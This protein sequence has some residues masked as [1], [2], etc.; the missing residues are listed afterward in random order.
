MP[1]IRVEVDG[2]TYEDDVEPRL[3]L[4]PYLH[5][6]LGR[7]CAAVGRETTNGGAC[8]FLMDGMSVQSCSVLAVQA[9]GSAVTTV[10]GLGVDGTTH[11][12][13]RA[14]HEEHALQCGYCTPGMIM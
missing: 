14:F 6:R 12:M 9:D 3:L 1:R 13:Q 10:E 5:D 4:V 2:T 8:S 7:V 11:P